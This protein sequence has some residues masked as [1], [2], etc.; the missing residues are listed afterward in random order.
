MFLVEIPRQTIFLI[1]DYPLSEATNPFSS[2][3]PCYPCLSLLFILMHKNLHCRV[4]V[5]SVR[6]FPKHLQNVP[7]RS[8]FS[9]IL[10]TYLM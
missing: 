3:L 4:K 8:H 9:L 6:Y 2:K 7:S 1:G 10:I 5:P